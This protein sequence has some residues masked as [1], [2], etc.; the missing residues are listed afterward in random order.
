[1]SDDPLDWVIEYLEADEDI[2]VPIKKMWNEWEAEHREPHL[3]PPLL[4]EQDGKER[5]DQVC[6]V[7]LGVFLHRPGALR[8]ASKYLDW[9]GLAPPQP[10]LR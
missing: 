6:D 10:R 8:S 2:V 9:G 4:Q 1:M 7:E 3:V 5:E